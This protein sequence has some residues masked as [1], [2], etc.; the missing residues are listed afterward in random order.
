MPSASSAK[1]P[2][3]LV[4]GDDAREVFKSSFP[5]ELVAFEIQEYVSR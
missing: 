3:L 1:A 2:V 5:S 4:C